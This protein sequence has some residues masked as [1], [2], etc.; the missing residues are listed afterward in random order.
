[1]D[2]ADSPN[3]QKCSFPDRS[4]K[5]PVALVIKADL[6]QQVF[7]DRMVSQVRMETMEGQD[8]ME[9]MRHP[10]PPSNH[11]HLSRAPLALRLQPVVLDYLDQRDPADPLETLGLHHPISDPALLED[12]VFPDLPVSPAGLVS[13]DLLAAPELPVRDRVHLVALETLD[14]KGERDFLVPLDA[15]EMEHLK[16]LLE[17]LE[18]Q[19]TR[20][21]LVFPELLVYLVLVVSEEELVSA[22]IVHL[23][24]LLQATD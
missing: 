19:E 13:K 23:Q 22:T 7:Q 12:P 10:G 9:G 8:Q 16:V 5:K 17:P 6:D 20:G 3:R 1:M 4:S 24:E 2:T 18:T 11:C 14:L 21:A 15:Q